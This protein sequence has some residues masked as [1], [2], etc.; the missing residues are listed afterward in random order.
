MAQLHS[1]FRSQLEFDTQRYL[2]DYWQAKCSHGNAPSRQDICP[3]GFSKVLSMI[4][5]VDVDN[6]D[7]SCQYRYRLAGTGLR[8]H[9]RQEITGKTFE[10]INKFGTCEQ[11]NEVFDKIV[12][13]KKPASGFFR[14]SS[15]LQNMTHFWIRLPLVDS[16][17][18]V[19]MVLCYDIF[20]PLSASFSQKSKM[21]NT[22]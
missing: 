17:G 10:Q 15:D 5:L 12:A 19:N 8:N 6:S 7:N 11:W 13:S 20:A 22:A 21:A 18:Q 9:Y 3:S 1:I 16:S 14:K 4:S 2:F